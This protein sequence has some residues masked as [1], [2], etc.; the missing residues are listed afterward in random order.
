MPWLWHADLKNEL[1]G[2][3]VA[4]KVEFTDQ[5]EAQLR[6]FDRYADELKEI[7]IMKYGAP[8][9]LKLH[10]QEGIGLT[11]KTTLPSDEQLAALLHRLRPFVLQGEYTNFR[12][13][14]N[15]IGRRAQT[16]LIHLF[17]RMQKDLYQ[18]KRSQEMI[19]VSSNG[20]M[21][22][23]EEILFQWLNGYEYHHDA[24]KR[25]AMEELHHLLPLE[26]S[27]ALFVTMLYDKADAI[28]NLHSLVRLILR[29]QETWTWSVTNA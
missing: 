18:S 25:L 13:V 15:T 11:V 7:S 1:D 14:A 27:K 23:S 12:Y 19:K 4:V 22:N 17:L 8:G 9:Q 28:R 20:V 29:K 10:W 24:D 16:E 21:I 3:D 6:A 2:T 26:A 5:E